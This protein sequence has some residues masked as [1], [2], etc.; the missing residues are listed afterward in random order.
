MNAQ[1]HVADGQSVNGGA[2]SDVT[3]QGAATPLTITDTPTL[4]DGKS[5]PLLGTSRSPDDALWDI[6]T[7]DISALFP[8]PG[9]YGITITSDS[10]PADCIA[11]VA[12]IIDLAAA[13]PGPPPPVCGNGVREGFEEC[14]DGNLLDGDCCDSTC[15]FEPA[16][17]VCASAGDPCLEALCDGAGTCDA[18][19]L[20]CRVPVA[21]EAGRLVLRHGRQDR[22][23]WR[24][25]TGFS[26]KADFGDPVNATAYDLCLYDKGTGSL[27]LVA[28]AS[29]SAG[30][31]CSGAPCWNETPRGYKYRNPAG[32]LQ[33]LVLQGD[34]PGRA[35][36]TA[37]SAAADCRCRCL[38]PRRC[39]C[40][41]GRG[42]GSAGAGTTASRRATGAG[43]SRA[44]E[45]ST[46][47]TRPLGSRSAARKFSP[48]RSLG[49]LP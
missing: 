24:W 25:T 30:E 15:H 19:G 31:S 36:I 11:L 32:P 23:T 37:R 49:L 5:V 14:D 27:R 29:A 39:W 48:H 28:R 7:F 21:P 34:L 44:A 26:I 43:A 4:W 12:V 18:E 6:H 9:R 45:T 10:Y 41:C 46:T 22:L 33:Q 38:S 13:P 40:A 3:L 8:A 16:G 47:R 35:Q 1:F 2:D 20:S 17:T 42:T